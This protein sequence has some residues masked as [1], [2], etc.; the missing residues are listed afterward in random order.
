MRKITNWIR[1]RLSKILSRCNNTVGFSRQILIF[2]KERIYELWD[3]FSSK[4]H[5]NAINNCEEEIMLLK[6]ILSENCFR[7]TGIINTAFPFLRIDDSLASAFILFE[8]EGLNR[9][10]VVDEHGC[11]IGILDRGSIL[12][13]F[14]PSKHLLRHN[15]SLQD[16]YLTQRSCNAIKT[17]SKENLYNFS[18]LI[19]KA[20]SFKEDEFISYGIRYLASNSYYLADDLLVITDAKTSVVGTISGKEIIAYL[21]KCIDLNPFSQSIKLILSEISLASSTAICLESESLESGLYTVNYTPTICILIK[22]RNELVGIITRDMIS[23]LIH[24]LYPQFLGYSMG[25]FMRSIDPSDIVKTETTLVDLCRG[26]IRN[27][28][29]FIVVGDKLRSKKSYGTSKDFA[30]HIVSVKSIL[31][32]MIS[33]IDLN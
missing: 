13:E 19:R 15:L 21:I 8:S 30:Y 5:M 1:Y 22:K 11:L 18:H 24:P 26:L 32:W 14:P 33:K 29:D 28:D 25:K 7:D 31:D 20:R 12:S 16:K 3:M 2:R 10:V 27:H 17:I 9:V 6:S 4:N 23:Q